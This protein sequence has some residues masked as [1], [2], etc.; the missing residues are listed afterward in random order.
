MKRSA[1][2]CEKH[3]YSKD[4]SDGPECEQCGAASGRLRW[5]YRHG[6]VYCLE[7][8]RAYG[9][10]AAEILH[11]CW[12]NEEFPPP[13]GSRPRFFC[14]PP[15]TRI[16]RKRP[17]ACRYE[18]TPEDSLEAAHRLLKEHEALLLP[19]LVLNMANAHYAGGGFLKDSTGQEEELCRRSD[20]FPRLVEA[21]IAGGYSIPD[22]GC[23]VAPTVR[24]LR[25]RCAS[26]DDSSKCT[27][28]MLPHSFK[29]AVITA[30]APCNPDLSNDE[31]LAS[32]TAAMRKR[33]DA[34]LSVAEHLDYSVLV[35]GAW[36]CGAFR[37]P[38]QQVARMFHEAL[39]GRFASS[40]K[41]VVFAVYDRPDWEETNCTIFK[42]ELQALL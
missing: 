37:N 35:L 26:T 5:S 12:E 4:D 11:V 17:L 18:V 3:W 10:E 27:Y 9:S 22:V 34:L 30:A 13:A 20:L 8:W 40:F 7:C 39:A 41:H 33:V 36:G 25:K 16:A 21:H 19:P 15:S 2:E 29:V 23:I 1:S 14:E 6:D 42:Q 31:A 28:E 24:V 38:P 32:Y